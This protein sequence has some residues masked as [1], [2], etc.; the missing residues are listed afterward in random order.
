MFEV[1]G[2]TP[3]LGISNSMVSISGIIILVL[4]FCGICFIFGYIDR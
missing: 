3:I 4:A 1:S 2:A